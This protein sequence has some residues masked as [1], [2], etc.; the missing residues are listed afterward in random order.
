LLNVQQ[1]YRKRFGRWL[2]GLR[3][4]RGYDSQRAFAKVAGIDHTR[5]NKI[6]NAKTGID[7]DTVRQLAAGLNVPDVV[8]Q[9]E[10]G[11]VRALSP[12]VAELAVRI[13]RLSPGGQELIEGIVGV[14]ERQENGQTQRGAST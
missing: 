3:E 6:E 9:V 12:A 1:E 13:M 5:I 7:A 14:V 8:A 4:R 11:Y 2:A 10:A